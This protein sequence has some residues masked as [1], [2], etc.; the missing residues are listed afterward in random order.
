MLTGGGGGGGAV[1][2]QGYVEVVVKQPDGSQDRHWVTM[3]PTTGQ[4]FGGIVNWPTKG[5]NLG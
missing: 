2:M 5:S 3:S 4:P 1:A